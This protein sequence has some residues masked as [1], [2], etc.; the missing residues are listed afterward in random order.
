MATIQSNLRRTIR[1]LVRNPAF[2]LV[3]IV[4]LALGIG[5]NT[6]IFTL[7]NALL[8]RD[9]PVREPERLV[10]LSALRAGNKIPFSFPM[11]QELERGQRVFSG[12]FGWSRNDASNVEINGSLSQANVLGVTG[13][14]YSELGVTPYLG[15][16][17]APDDATPGAA[18]PVAVIGYQYWKARFAGSPNVIGDQILIEGQPFTI[19]GVTRKWFT[20]MTTGEPPDVTIPITAEHMAW[21][22]PSKIMSDRSLLWIAATGRLKDH[23]TLDQARAQLQSFW[24]EVLAATSPTQTP[25]LRRDTFFAMGLDVSPAAKGIAADLRAEFTRPLYFLMGVV[26]LILL[27]AC[28]NLANLMLARAASH[29]QEM[30]VRVALG[31]SRWTLARQVLRET[32]TL[33]FIGAAVG[34]GFAYWGSRLL[35]RLMTRQYFTPV[36]LNLNPDLRVL[37]VTFGIAAITGIL[38]GL[39]PAWRYSR[40]DPAVVLRQN[41]RSLAGG[42]SRLSKLLIVIQVALSLILLLGAGLLLRTFEGLRSV[43]TGFSRESVLEVTLAARPG[44]PRNFDAISYRRQLNDLVSALPGVHSLS[45]SDYP[46]PSEQG[47][48]QTV[49][50]T[51]A[52][53][54]SS[55]KIMTHDITVFPTFLDTVGIPLLRGRGLL[56]TD[57]TTEPNV[58]I[59][60]TSLANSLFPKG[61]AI[62]RHIRVGFMPEF[63]DLEVVGITADAR[64]FDL[65][66]S[67]SPL[68]Y[69]PALQHP[70]WIRWDRLYLFVRSA[71]PPDVL[72]RTVASA[73]DSLGREYVLG[74]RT[75]AQVMDGTL[76]EERVIAAL[77]SFFAALAL[78]L[79]S[80]G[81]YGLMSYAVT[82]RTREIG[83]RVALGAQ[84]GA[85]LRLVLRESLFLVFLGIALGIPCALA[86]ARLVGSML[87]GIS[88]NDPATIAA[89]S[90]LLLLVAFFAGYLPARRASRIDPI[91]ALRCE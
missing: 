55:V 1:S 62:G 76:V 19:V 4:S 47:F 82:R 9:L 14:Y 70:D 54:A 46:I 60:S 45:L 24:P 42:A 23:L 67:A 56:W 90:L 41:S 12:L 84:P 89:I 10:E 22:D 11:F 34:L 79:A 88:P 75:V 29:S 68:V 80:I 33:S 65:R 73:V 83:I 91:T 40:Q 25:G 61:R 66:S 85:V 21:A 48:P 58:A 57:D 5:A 17:I 49:S 27:V 78:L 71:Q 63:Q 36:V 32:L 52:D 16:L 7:V 43:D 20:G 51:G 39:A 35:V 69:I 50:E 72:G 13:N 26:G 8:L 6:A 28:A 53:A 64:I 30:G 31:A 59:I 87:F 3:A 18:L 86:A 77:S 37:A 44:T 74:A 81:L 15:R 2:S 38:F